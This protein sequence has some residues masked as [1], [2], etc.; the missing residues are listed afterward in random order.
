[1]AMAEA[2][3]NGVPA[4]STALGTATDWVNLDG[5]TGLV[6]PPNDVVALAAAI[7]RLRDGSLR[8][9][10]GAQAA[11]RATTLFSFEQHIVDLEDIYREATT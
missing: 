4:V 6:V 3:A 2:M 1:M 11:K 10:L 7:E 9:R 8:A 5:R